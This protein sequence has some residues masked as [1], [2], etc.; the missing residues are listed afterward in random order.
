MTGLLSQEA[1]RFFGIRSVSFLCGETGMSVLCKPLLLKKK[2]WVCTCSDAVFERGLLTITFL[3]RSTADQTC[4]VT[5]KKSDEIPQLT[6]CYE[7]TFENADCLPE[8]L[9]GRITQYRK[10][11]LGSRRRQ[12][13]R[14]PVGQEHWKDFKLRMPDCRLGNT[15]GISVP[16]VIINASVHGALVIGIRSLN[17][18]VGDGLFLAA[19]FT[20]GRV[21]QNAMLVNTE[22]VHDKYWRY[23]LHFSEPVSLAWLTHLGELADASDSEEKD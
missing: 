11:M 17:F 20:D 6:N 8:F 13:R 9:S 14:F 18:H 3:D 16:C 15:N 2:G 4:N 22:S 10:L 7:M 23:S 5:A 21:L 1:L 19:D 12:E